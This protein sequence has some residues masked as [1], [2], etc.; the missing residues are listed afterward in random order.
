M[1]RRQPSRRVYAIT[2]TSVYESTNTAI[3]SIQ[4]RRS[5]VQLQGTFPSRDFL[6]FLNM[7]TRSWKIQQQCFRLWLSA[8]VLTSQSARACVKYC[9]VLAS[10]ICAGVDIWFEVRITVVLMA[11]VM[12]KCSPIYTAQREREKV[13]TSLVRYSRLASIMT[14]RITWNK[15]HAL[16]SEL[17]PESNVRQLSDSVMNVY[18][19]VTESKNS[20]TG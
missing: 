20:T 2:A 12:W 13:M 14:H 4:T 11:K 19:Q 9:L 7:G 8:I 17:E 6:P 15:S 3:I 18:I 1:L 16:A 5:Q 10:I